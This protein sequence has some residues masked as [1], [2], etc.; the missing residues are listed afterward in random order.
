MATEPA[1]EAEPKR[2]EDAVGYF[3][4][5]LATDL[6]GLLDSA[7]TLE[8]RRLRPGKPRLVR[9]IPLTYDSRPVVHGSRTD[10]S[11]DSIA[12]EL[13]EHAER[14]AD[15]AC[16]G[17]AMYKVTLHYAK[18]SRGVTSIPRSFELRVGFVSD[19]PEQQQKLDFISTLL[20]ERDKLFAHQLRLYDAATKVVTSCATMAD[21][22]AGGFVKLHEGQSQVAE[23]SDLRA[24]HQ[25]DHAQEQFRVSAFTDLV[26]QVMPMVRA[27]LGVPEPA[28]ALAPATSGP[29]AIA[30][31]FAQSLKPDQLSLIGRDM[32]ELREA[33]TVTDEPGLLRVLVHVLGLP[34]DKVQPLF[35]S[36][37]AAQQDQ[38]T[39]LILWAQEQGAAKAAAS[40]RALPS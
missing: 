10:R 19:S 4:P 13:W 28:N 16:N 26:K 31:A 17:S 30:R 23:V 1:P 7:T 37:D 20:A 5:E 38:F 27:K 24:L 33:A 25:A 11:V 22:L 40:Q 29:L 2:D 9:R 35:D 15:D 12:S 21:A 8:C 34:N 3:P 14:D 36:F 6:E 18:P 32:P 39:K